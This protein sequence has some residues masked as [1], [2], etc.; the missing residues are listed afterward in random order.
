MNFKDL[1]NTAAAA[2]VKTFS[3][4]D[5]PEGTYITEV[6]SCKLGPTRAGDKDMVSWDLKVVEG[7]QKNSHIFVNRAF[8]KT[9]ASEQNIKAVERALNDFKILELPCTD[10]TIG[11]TMKDIVGKRIE[12]S[13]KNGTSG[14]FKNFKRIVEEVKTVANVQEVSSFGTEVFPEEEIPF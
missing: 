1:W 14:Q 7:E 2:E 4:E 9:D 10:T 8:S 13:L 11:K 12:I 3:N 6:I 5:L